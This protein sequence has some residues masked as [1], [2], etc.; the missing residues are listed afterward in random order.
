[1]GRRLTELIAECSGRHGTVHVLWLIWERL[2]LSAQKAIVSGINGR[3]AIA[4]FDL[5]LDR[6][7]LERV[8]SDLT[9]IKAALEVSEDF[10][11][12]INSPIISR[13]DQ[14]RTVAALGAKIGTS[15]LVQNFL[16]VLAGNGRL[17]YLPAVISDIERLSADYRGEITAY[18]TSAHPL[19]DEQITA[20]GREL[21]EIAGRDVLIEESVN[22]ELL[23]G[24][25]VRLGSRM[26]DGSLRRKLQNLRL[27]MKGVG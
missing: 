24:L 7:A 23:G 27:A 18:V 19:S 9:D 16:G 21:R 15:E 13:A 11:Q 2:V 5:A 8:L 6:D 20:L 10:R 22:K 14:V 25:S 1:M 26:I 3:Y 12:F 17:K 4:L